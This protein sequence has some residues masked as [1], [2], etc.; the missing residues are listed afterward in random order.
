MTIT[1]LHP[2]PGLCYRLEQ[3]ILAAGAMVFAS[4][5]SPD[6]QHFEVSNPHHH[7]ALV[8]QDYNKAIFGG[9]K[10]HELVKKAI[11]SLLVD[12]EVV[13]C[14]QPLEDESFKAALSIAEI[15]DIPVATKIE[16][17][18]TLS[19]KPVEK[20]K[21]AR[22]WWCS[23]CAEISE[24]PTTISDDTPLSGRAVSACVGKSPSCRFFPTLE[25]AQMDALS[26]DSISMFEKEEVPYF[27]STTTYQPGHPVIKRGAIVFPGGV[28]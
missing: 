10:S 14:S 12:T 24:S 20:E 8:Y 11:V 7:A 23:G 3:D 5:N 16:D 27:D 18:F 2:D 25:E 28:V 26:D 17:I 15:M 21:P 22:K 1:I 13:L 6:N 9:E 19:E 4:G